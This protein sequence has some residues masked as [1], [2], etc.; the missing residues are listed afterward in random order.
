VTDEPVGDAPQS[1]RD[2]VPTMGETATPGIVQTE[3][4][5]AWLED[6][7]ECLH[8]QGVGIGQGAVNVE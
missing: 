5:A 2:G 8:V 3:D 6:M 1:V 7:V 4:M